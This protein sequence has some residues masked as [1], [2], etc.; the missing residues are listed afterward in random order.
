MHEELAYKFW[1][2]LPP[3]EDEFKLEYISTGMMNTAELS[4]EEARKETVRLGEMTQKMSKQFQNLIVEEKPKQIQKV[5]KK[6][7]IPTK[8][9]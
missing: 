4:I 8:H 1:I 6:K 7:T 2:S 5:V 3:G 9:K